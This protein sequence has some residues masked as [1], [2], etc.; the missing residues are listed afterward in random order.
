MSWF[1]DICY[2]MALTWDTEL[3]DD[4]FIPCKRFCTPNKSDLIKSF[5][6]RGMGRQVWTPHT[7][8]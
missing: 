7:N 5:K 2:D 1:A 4:T 3:H 6:N 8:V